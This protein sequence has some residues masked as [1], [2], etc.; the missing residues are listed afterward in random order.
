M[1]RWVSELLAKTCS[2][3]NSS[4]VNHCSKSISNN[5]IVTLTFHSFCRLSD[6]FWSVDI[7]IL[8]DGGDSS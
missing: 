3:K 2:Q 8:D 7:E 4:S 6:Y 1:G 5:V